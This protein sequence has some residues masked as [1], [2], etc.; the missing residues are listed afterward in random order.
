MKFITAVLIVL[1]AVW[2]INYYTDFDLASL[3]L[4]PQA[5]PDSALVKAGEECMAIAEQ[6][7]AHLIPKVEFQKLEFAARKANVFVRCMGDRKYRQNPAWLS[8]A[9]TQAAKDALSQHISVDEALENLKRKDMLQFH[10]SSE[11]PIY[12]LAVSSPK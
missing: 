9:Q 10:P 2:G 7:S 6:A 12:W 1:L 8:Y 11:K 3:S 4:Q 5:K